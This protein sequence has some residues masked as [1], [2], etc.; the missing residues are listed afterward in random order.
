HRAFDLGMIGLVQF[1]PSLLLALPAGHIADQ[2]DR[3]RIVLTC[4]IIECV[5][6]AVLAI[7]STRGLFGEAAILS[8]VFLIGVAKAIEFPTSQALM[9]ALVP[10]ALFPRATAV[11][12]S[13]GQTAMIAGPAI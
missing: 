12:A 2:Y 10:P 5:A 4:V 11:V 9:P 6:M 8:I 3:R 1:V 13:A 7:A